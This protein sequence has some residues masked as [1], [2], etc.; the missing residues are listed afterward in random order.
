MILTGRCDKISMIKMVFVILLKKEISKEAK[1]NVIQ[2]DVDAV[3][4]L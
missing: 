3:I 4:S 2:C 1:F